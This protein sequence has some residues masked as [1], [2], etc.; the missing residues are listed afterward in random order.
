MNIPVS[1]KK[2]F[3]PD[4]FKKIAILWGGGL[5]DIIVISPL[6]RA[7]NKNTNAEIYLLTTATHLPNLANEFSLNINTV[8][9]DSKITKLPGILKRWWGKFDFVYLGPYPG[10]KTKLLGS[11]LGL[12]STVWN[13]RHYN[14]NRFIGEQIKADMEEMGLNQAS[15]DLLHFSTH[16]FI[17][18]SDYLVV[19]AGSKDRW[20][21]KRWPIQKWKELINLILK[22]T[23][24]SV[25]LIGT[26]NEET[27]MDSII[28]SL[29]NGFRK[30]I[31][32][33]ISEPLSFIIALISKSTGVVCHNSGILH[34]STLL[35]KQ[36]VA[37]TGSSAIYWR[38]QYPWISNVTSESCKIACNRYKC[39]VPFYNAKCINKISVDVVWSKIKEQILKQ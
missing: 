17:K 35:K 11:F 21:T 4:E 7:L 24:L 16:K 3:Q 2:L 33:Y 32:P 14:K 5:G 27:M 1:H 31:I 23:N 39:P 6:I 18:R 38:P 12:S 36:T 19:H 26:E 37:I 13:K 28:V 10:L 8:H 25:C 9:L 15:P 22:E 29:P 20:E 30:R 34:L